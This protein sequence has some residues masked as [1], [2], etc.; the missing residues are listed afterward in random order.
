MS[1]VAEKNKMR[2]LIGQMF[3]GAIVGAIAVSAFIAF[4][5]KPHMDLKD[6]AIMV[7]I[8]AGVSYVLIGLIV[9]AGLAS[10]KAGAHFLNVED[11]EEIREESPKLI[12]AAVVFVL[13]GIFLLLLATYRTG[14]AP[15]GRGMV[16]T[17]AAVCF[18]GVVI[19]GWI[20]SKRIDELT[21]QLGLET[22]A[23]TF[24]VT[25]LFLCIWGTLAHLDYVAWLSPLA[26]LSS[27]A[28]LQLLASFVI[29]ARKGM[30]MPR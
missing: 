22:A 21:R 12:P 24:Q 8:V 25:M 14:A 6:P 29:I 4:V 13:T 17:A 5:G 9:A 11:A 30:L 10:P 28:L 20:S 7:T 16:L 18:G 15:M 19:A 3:G 27:V 23:V 26:L 1:G 2:V